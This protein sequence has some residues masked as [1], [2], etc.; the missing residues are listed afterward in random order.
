MSRMRNKE[1]RRKRMLKRGMMVSI[2]VSALML[3][4]YIVSE[5]V[6]Y[7]ADKT[8]GAVQLQNTS[9]YEPAFGEERERT[10]EELRRYFDLEGLSVVE[11]AADDETN[12]IQLSHEDEE[13]LLQIGVAEAEGE[14][15]DGIAM[16]MRVVLNRK[17]SPE[18]P[19]TVEGVV[20]QEGQ[21]TPVK[22]GG[23]Y[24]TTTPNSKCYEALEMVESG[25][26]ESQGA[27][28]FESGRNKNSWH[29]RHL[30]YLFTLGG[31][32]FYK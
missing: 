10:T 30:Q 32:K 7:G 18:W 6:A 12:P 19:D 16:V 22:E 1:M 14:P 26:D 28:Y 9:I 4:G 13:I 5:T 29:S 23:R 21:F 17:E 3:G 8:D 31:H 24:Y 11:K 2:G 15:V 27:M 25:W 20:F